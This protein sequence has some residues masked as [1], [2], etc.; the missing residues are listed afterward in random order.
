MTSWEPL[1][2]MKLEGHQTPWR[3]YILIL[4]WAISRAAVTHRWF[5][6]RGGGEGAHTAL[7][8]NQFQLF[9]VVN[10]CFKCV[11]VPRDQGS[12]WDTPLKYPASL[13][14]PSSAS[15]PHNHYQVRSSLSSCLPLLSGLW[16]VWSVVSPPGVCMLYK[17][18][19][20]DLIHKLTSS[21]NTGRGK[22]TQTNLWSWNGAV[23]LASKTQLG[24]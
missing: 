3:F 17:N 22:G 13:S 24:M 19:T 23:L 1:V 21:I 18:C 7:H 6:C 15:G 10:L 16:S 20:G 9:L 11:E 12:P 2:S 8:R 4:I 5:R 14:S